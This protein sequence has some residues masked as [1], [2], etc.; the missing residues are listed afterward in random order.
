M[1]T[2][3]RHRKEERMET[4]ERTREQEI[5]SLEF[6]LSNLTLIRR[7]AL[8]YLDKA[9][10]ENYT[11]EEM[12]KPE[13]GEKYRNEV[14]RVQ[15]TIGTIK[16]EKMKELTK[17]RSQYI[18]E[19]KE[20]LKQ[21]IDI[22]NNEDQSGL[23]STLEKQVVFFSLQNGTVSIS[24]KRYDIPIMEYDSNEDKLIWNQDLF[25]EI[26]PDGNFAEFKKQ[27]TE[28]LA[29][30]I[31]FVNTMEKL[32]ETIDFVGPDDEIDSWMDEKN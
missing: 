10:S 25:L 1:E 18:E 4:T 15:K 17:L 30:T 2:D 5:K 3:I 27:I 28:D 19:K 13:M 21:L 16:R 22:C 26:C 14:H 6:T 7:Y 31:A 9:Y 29:K 12:Q 32:T 20:F 11:Q 24:K 23:L 8:R